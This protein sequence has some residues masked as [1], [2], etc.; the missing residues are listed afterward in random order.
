MIDRYEQVLRRVLMGAETVGGAGAATAPV[1]PEGAVE[2]GGDFAATLEDAKRR[3]D[4]LDRDL[5]QVQSMELLTA[6]KNALA[7][8]H[9]MKEGDIQK[10]WLSLNPAKEEENKALARLRSA[11]GKVSYSA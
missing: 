2:T 10:R 9:K 1:L 8:K 3:L 7:K 6:V 5:A 4:A 11:A